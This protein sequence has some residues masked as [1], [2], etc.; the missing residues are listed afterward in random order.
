MKPIQNLEN[1]ST[2]IKHTIP[3][4]AFGQG[5]LLDIIS[6]GNTIWIS[7]S[8]QKDNLLTTLSVAISAGKTVQI[9]EW[10]EK[11]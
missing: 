10:K 2:K 8:I 5:G 1:I 4:A 11:K 7:C 3:V 6:E 9:E